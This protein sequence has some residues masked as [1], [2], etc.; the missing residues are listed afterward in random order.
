MNT[1]VPESVGVS[2]SRLARLGRCMEAYIDR[3]DFAGLVVLIARHGAVCYLETFGQM[4]I[5]AQKPMAVDTIFRIYSMSK[6]IT[7]VAALTLYEQGRFQLTTPVSEF[8]PAFKD[9]QVLRSF[10]ETDIEFEPLAREM[11]VRDL[12]T[13]T[14]GLTYGF[15]DSSPIEEMYRQHIHGDKFL[16][17]S[18]QETMA[19]LADLPLVHQPGTA[20]RYSVSTD[21]LGY[22]VEAASGMPLGSFLQQQVFEPLGM[23]DTGFFV[24]PDR[25][26]R[27]AANYAPE[28]DGSLRLV[29]APSTGIYSRPPRLESGGGGLASTIGDYFQFAQMLLN[30]G[31]WGGERILSR[32]TIELAMMNH[33]TPE[34]LPSYQNPGFGF[35]LGGKVLMDPAQAQIVGSPGLF[36]WGGAATTDFWIDPTEQLVGVI[37]PQLMDGGEY[38]L[39][40]DFQVLVYQAL[41]D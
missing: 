34:M 41:D 26:D 10:T 8:I 11:T 39:Q 27:L 6:P 15:D 36:G 28:P 9:L 37:M 19:L 2:S 18:L 1:V 3:G 22:I 5:E 25:I 21:V 17:R 24:P 20:W 13:H 35:G 7:T 23:Q 30:G 38:P 29:D 32:K 14:S 33:L 16:R 40:A 4:D 12:M 31:T